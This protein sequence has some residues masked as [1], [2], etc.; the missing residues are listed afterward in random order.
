TSA[1]LLA[2]FDSVRKTQI[3]AYADTVSSGPL[4]ESTP[5]A[6]SISAQREIK[7]LGVTYW[8]L[9]NGVRV[10]LKPTD[11]KADQVL[12]RAYSPGGTSLLSDRDVT[13]AGFA[14][15][16]AQSGGVGRFSQIDLQK[17]LA[18][19]LAAVSPSIS[20]LQEGLN[21]S[22]SPKDLETLFQLINLYF[23]KPR[24]DS[25]AFLALKGQIKASIANRGSQPEA[26]FGDTLQ[27]TLT[28]NHPRAR[29]LTNE[30]LDSISLVKSMAFYKERFADA[31]DFT[32]VFV[33][34]FDLDSI[35]PLVSTYLGGLPSLKRKEN[36]RDVGIRYPTGVIKKVVR[37]GSE[38]KG[39]TQIVFTGPFTW[40]RTNR[41]A[42]AS[43]TSVL[44]IRLRE[45]LREDL[46]GVYGVSVGDQTSFEPR[47]EYSFRIGFG[48]SP[49]RIDTLRAEVFA[50]IDSIKN[51]GPT[52]QD[53][54]KVRETQRRGEE[55]S[56]KENGYWL[57]TLIA[58]D[59]FGEDPHILLDN[60]AMRATLS[61]EMIRDA[62]RR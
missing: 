18:G 20:S 61:A 24:Q 16:V 27:A 26:V 47:P 42:I 32:F 13:A 30:K 50:V 57:A 2:V 7:D 23:T 43:L 15:I 22:A 3:V 41:Y 5:R 12:V 62:A 56:R 11:F 58:A 60:E 49:D 4:I 46:G 48:A 19:K 21:G 9:S 28:Q 6:G 45:V 34:N 38:P 52:A 10:I 37:K 17:A 36:W 29:P 1:E 39:Q 25:S 53:L 54:E 51:S 40:N 14:S 31:S 44:R 35:K 8:T 55:T 33:G 59:R